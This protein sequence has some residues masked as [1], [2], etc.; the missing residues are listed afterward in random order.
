MGQ[1]GGQVQLEA[2]WEGP[3]AKGEASGLAGCYEQHD[4]AA[5]EAASEAA[6][7]EGVQTS[8]VSGQQHPAGAECRASIRLGTGGCA[9]RR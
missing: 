8:T 2:P 4:A 7:A 1:L 5:A 9:L 3:G 6:A